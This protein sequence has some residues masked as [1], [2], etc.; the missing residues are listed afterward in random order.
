MRGKT[1]QWYHCHLDCTMRK[2]FSVPYRGW[3]VVRPALLFAFASHLNNLLPL[4]CPVGLLEWNRCKKIHFIHWISFI[5]YSKDC[6]ISWLIQLSSYPKYVKYIYTCIDIVIGTG[7]EY[8][9][10][11][12]IWTM[13]TKYCQICLYG[14]LFNAIGLYTSNISVSWNLWLT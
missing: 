9:A 12:I 1:T 2:A 7:N 4:L 5:Q 8:C 14:H 3:V 10:S 11:S 6:K 13:K